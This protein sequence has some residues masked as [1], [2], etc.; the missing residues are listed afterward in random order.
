MIC[1]D[2]Q[3]ISL[4]EDEGFIHS[5]KVTAPLYKSPSRQTT[6]S[7]IDQKY[8]AVAL[9]LRERLGSVPNVCLTTDIWTE[10][11]QTRSFLGVTVHLIEKCILGSTILGVYELHENHTAHLADQS[12]E[13]LF[14]LGTDCRKNYSCGYKGGE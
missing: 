5:I 7:L 12:N 11:H 1:E 4:V 2:S 13:N 14:G 10:T 9:I 3:P 6:N 8:E